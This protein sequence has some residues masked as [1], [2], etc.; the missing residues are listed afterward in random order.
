MIPFSFYICFTFFDFFLSNYYATI[1]TIH[2]AMYLIV[3][4][5]VSLARAPITSLYIKIDVETLIEFYASKVIM[6]GTF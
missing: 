2:R 4:V 6:D 5:N 3:L 1:Y